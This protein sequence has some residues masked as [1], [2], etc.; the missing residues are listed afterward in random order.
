MCFK[1]IPLTL[2]LRIECRVEGRTGKTRWMSNA[3]IH[4]RDLG[5]SEQGVS[6]EIPDMI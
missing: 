2:I 4:G 1:R 3:V 6:G 5:S